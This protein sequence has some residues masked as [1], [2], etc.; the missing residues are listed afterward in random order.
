VGYMGLD[1]SEINNGKVNNSITSMSKILQLK[2]DFS[3]TT[4]L[5]VANLNFGSIR[6]LGDNNWSFK[7]L[8]KQE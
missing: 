1:K 6:L 2:S 8:L 7:T 4:G 3:Q 5:I